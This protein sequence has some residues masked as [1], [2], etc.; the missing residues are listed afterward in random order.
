MLYLLTTKND[1]KYYELI[2][3]LALIILQ[4]FFFYFF[5]IVHLLNVKKKIKKI[6]F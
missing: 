4:L 5:I 3:Q 1:F 6:I 2:K